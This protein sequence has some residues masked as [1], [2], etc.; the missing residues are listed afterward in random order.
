LPRRSLSDLVAGLVALRSD[1]A[2]RV[3]LSSVEPQE[4]DERLVEMMATSDVLAP[5]LHLPLQSGSDTMLRGMR[6]SYRTAAYRTQVQKVAGRISPVALGAD[7][8]VGFPGETEEDFRKTLAFL[9][10]LPFTYL[11]PFTYSPRPG[12]PAAAWKGRP[13]GDVAA[14]RLASAQALIRE[15]NRAF[16]RSLVGRD[17]KVLVEETGPDGQS[18]GF[19]EYYVRVYFKGNKNLEGRFALV[20]LTGLHKDGLGGQLLEAAP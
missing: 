6:R 11:H 1:H 8:I 20:N 7:L 4:I 17:A 10:E 9:A 12:T 19:G 13:P 5:H 14:R 15:K 16:R 18:F 3:R 2:Y